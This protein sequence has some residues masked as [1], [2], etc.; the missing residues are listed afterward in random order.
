MGTFGPLRVLAGV[1]GR[2]AYDN[3]KS[4]VIQVGHGS[5]CTMED[6]P[7]RILK[8]SYNHPRS[9]CGGRRPGPQANVGLL[10]F[11]EGHARSGPRLARL[12]PACG[13]DAPFS[14]VAK[15]ITSWQAER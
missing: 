3:L 14:S 1:P 2:L 13:T 10:I 9:A 5:R 15:E 11:G 6:D 4:A 7:C 8:A 12:A